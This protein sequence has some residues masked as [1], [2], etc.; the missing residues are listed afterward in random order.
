[1]GLRPGNSKWNDGTTDVLRK[2]PHEDTFL[3]LYGYIDRVLLD[4]QRKN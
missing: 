4:W 2:I 1:M 3:G